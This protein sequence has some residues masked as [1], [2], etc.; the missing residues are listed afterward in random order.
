MSG[1]TC[2]QCGAQYHDNLDCGRSVLCG[3]SYAQ[4][5]LTCKSC[6]VWREDPRLQD[7]PPDDYEVWEAPAGV[8]L[9]PSCWHE[10][11]GDSAEA[12]DKSFGRMVGFLSRLLDQPEMKP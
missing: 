10:Q 3:S 12:R 5:S 1:G 11:R 6:A 8:G 9:C 7:R 4:H 2:K